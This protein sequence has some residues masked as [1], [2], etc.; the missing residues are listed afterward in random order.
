MNKLLIITILFSSFA[1]SKTKDQQGGWLGIFSKKNLTSKYFWSSEAQLRYNFDTGSVG[2][3]LYRTGLNYKV[4]DSTQSALLYGYIS[5]DNAKEHRWTLQSSKKY[6]LNNNFQFSSR[7][8]L[9]YR[10]LEDSDDNSLRLRLLLRADYKD[11]IFWNEI[12][13]NLTKDEWTGDRSFERNRL[14]IGHKLSV[15][16]S[17]VEFGYL[18]QYIPREESRISEHVL[19]LYFFM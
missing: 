5:S 17:K 9:E 4:S 7:S 16:D 2:Q 11:Y 12:F 6:S 3:F 18:N 19:V 1:F 14:F 13:M 8:R 15:F 10:N